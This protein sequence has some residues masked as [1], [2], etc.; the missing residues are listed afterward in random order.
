[1]FG[2]L[3]P[4]L[5]AG[6]GGPWFGRA[7][8]CREVESAWEAARERAQAVAELAKTPGAKMARAQQGIAHRRRAWLRRDHNCRQ[9]PSTTTTPNRL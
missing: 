5:A 1:M 8:S 7:G 4:R 3:P 9:A 2:A 6:A